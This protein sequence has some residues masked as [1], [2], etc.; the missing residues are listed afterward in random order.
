MRPGRDQF[1][2]GIGAVG[3]NDC[4]NAISNMNVPFHITTKNKFARCH[5]HPA[6][7]GALVGG[8]PRR[9]HSSGTSHVIFRTFNY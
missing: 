1:L 5:A 8:A 9:W 7:E 3:L 4:V 6:V 2:P